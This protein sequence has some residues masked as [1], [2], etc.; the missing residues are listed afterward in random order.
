MKNILLKTLI[1]GI[2]LSFPQAALAE[3]P[4]AGDGL[5]GWEEMK[6]MSPDQ[7]AKAWEERREK[8][9]NMS[10]A[11]KNT[12]REERKAKWDALSRDE[13]IKLVNERHEVMKKHKEERWNRMSDDE[14]ISHVEE[15]MNRKR[16]GKCPCSD[17]PSKN[18]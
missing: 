1:I 4:R 6:D 9:N 18:N 2:A 8:W 13:K 14:K 15:R 5:I 16:D 10:E 7:R 12:F 3:N 11:D 17:K